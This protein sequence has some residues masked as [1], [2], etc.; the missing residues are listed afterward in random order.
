MTVVV[1]LCDG[2]SEPCSSYTDRQRIIDHIG[3]L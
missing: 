3:L 1:V 2:V